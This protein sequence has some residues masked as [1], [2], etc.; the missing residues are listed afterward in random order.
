M[1]DR[2][3]NIKLA[4]LAIIVILIIPLG[5]YT[6]GQIYYF[7]RVNFLSPIDLKSNTIPIRH[8]L[9]GEGDFGAPRRGKRVHQGVDILTEL[10]TSVRAVKS[11]RAYAKNQPQGLGKYVELI[12]PNGLVTIYAHLSK[13]NILSG[14]KVKQG[15]IIGYAGKTGN[16]RYKNIQPHLHFEVRRDGQPVDPLKG[17]LYSAKTEQQKGGGNASD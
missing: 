8:D 16:A 17:Y 3:V 2:K 10:G 14:Q 12:H 11:G 6:F 13:F 4:F 5:I 1:K 9:R 15:Q 7:D